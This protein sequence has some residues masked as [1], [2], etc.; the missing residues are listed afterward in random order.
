MSNVIPKNQQLAKLIDQS[1]LKPDVTKKD[2]MAFCKKAEE[3]GFWS[4]CINPI[5]VAL[6]ARLLRETAV[7]VTSVVGFP[8]GASVSEVKA[9]EAEKAVKDGANEID[10]VMN[11]GAF[12]SQEFDLVKKDIS[13]VVKR[14]KSLKDIIVKVIIET[15]LL[16]DYEKI[17]ACQIVKESG[18]D[19]V[20]TSTGFNG[21]GATVEDIKLIRKSVGGD[22]GIKASGGIRTR[23]DMIKMVEAGANRI[24]TSSGVEIIASD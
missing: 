21:P 20:K 16:T 13:M 2:V 18:A 5:Y 6:A 15:G 19:Y 22:F 8:L 14:V 12:K 24:G 23:K 10:V 9:L 1:L 17:V 7:K 11:I 3:Y 4:V